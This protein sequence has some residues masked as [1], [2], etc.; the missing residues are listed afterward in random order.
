MTTM[1][2]Q[3]DELSLQG[4]LLLQEPLADYTTWRVGGLAHKLYKPAGIDDLAAFLK[5][6]P[7][8]E[9]LL[10]IGLGS[11]S[12]I[13]DGGFSG[14]VI[15]TQGCLK[16]VQLVDETTVHVEAGV[17][18]ATM[19]RFCA[20]NNLAGGEFWAGIPGTMGGA[21]RM[22]A[23]CFGSETW[24]AVVEVE[25][26]TREG[27]RKIRTPEEFEIA[28]R[29]V[30]GLAE[31]EWFIAATCR[32]QKGEKEQSL[33]LIKELLAHRAETQPTSE[34]NCGSVFRNPPGDFAAR[35]IESCGLKGYQLG[36]AVVSTKHA[37]FII[38]QHGNASANDIES[39]IELVRETVRQQTAVELIREVHIIGAKHV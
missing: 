32:L 21:L 2:L 35:L 9:P 30:S 25:T 4:E 34:Y 7:A 22:N 10:W 39:L 38:N 12:L 36:G 8:D 28:Y 27:Q 37:N 11:N 19:A 1:N 6:L 29:H 16:N 3:T 17:S 31:D 15:L 26:M 5:Q 33:K 14:T 13:R 20:R 23:G 24:K 18:C